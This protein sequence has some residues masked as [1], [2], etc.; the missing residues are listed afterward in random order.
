M[1]NNKSVVVI[2]AILIFLICYLWSNEAA[3]EDRIYLTLGSKHYTGGDYCET[4]PGVGLET[5]LDNNQDNSWRGGGIFYS[6]SYCD[7]AVFAYVGTNFL[8]TKHLDLGF[9][10]GLLFGYKDHI[11]YPLAAG[12]TALIKPYPDNK[13][14]PDIALFGIPGSVVG[15]GVSW[16]LY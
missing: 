14:L 16:D 6:N 15:F 13:W 10:A 8:E 4:N 12:L 5:S 3:S 9:N 1:S 7:P 2:Y 11:R